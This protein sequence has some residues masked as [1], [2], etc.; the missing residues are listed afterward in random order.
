MLVAASFI[1]R[2]RKFRSCLIDLDFHVYCEVYVGECWFTYD[3]RYNVPRIG[4]V[5]VASGLDAVDGAFSTFY[6][7]VTPYVFRSLGLLNSGRH[8]LGGFTD[9]FV[10]ATRRNPA[11]QGATGEV[12]NGANGA[13]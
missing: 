11:Y 1:K 5:K 9:R 2:R 7:P 8:R 12:T 3:A 6:G 10:P 13:V 4:R